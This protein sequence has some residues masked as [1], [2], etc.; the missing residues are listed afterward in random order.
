M[1]TLNVVILFIS[2]WAFYAAWLNETNLSAIDDLLQGFLFNCE[3]K[4]IFD[5]QENIALTLTAAAECTKTF[6]L[7]NYSFTSKY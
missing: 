1:F 5:R 7:Q 4:K 3:K 6:G 2:R